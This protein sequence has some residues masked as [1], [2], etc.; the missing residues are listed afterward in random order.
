MRAPFQVLILPFQQTPKGLLVAVCHRSDRD[1]WQFVSGGGEDTETP[2]Q[3]ALRELWEETGHRAEKLYPLDSV[4]S[5]RADIYHQPQ[6][7]ER[8]LVVPE[9]C[10]A[11]PMQPE[12]IQ[13][14]HEHN[15]VVW[16]SPDEAAPRLTYDSNRTALY[17]LCARLEKGWL[18]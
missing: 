13:L 9:H 1:A 15:A 11:V 3:A 17:E 18:T 16:L 12:E 2:M 6:W 14:S 7:D 8:I 10:F 4:A 5:I